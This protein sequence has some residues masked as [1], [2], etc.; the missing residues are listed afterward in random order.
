MLV[1]GQAEVDVVVEWND[2][3]IAHSPE[4]RPCDGEPSDPMFLSD[5]GPEGEHLQQYAVRLL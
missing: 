2:A 1:D 5:S 4:E 3:L